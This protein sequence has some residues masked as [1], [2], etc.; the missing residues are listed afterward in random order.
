MELKPRNRRPH[1]LAACAAL[2][3]MVA[4]PAMAQTLT[5]TPI[6]WDV[7]GLDSND[8][9]VGPRDFPVGARICA[10]SGTSG[11]NVQAT[12]NWD[13]NLDRY[14]GNA[15]INLRTGTPTNSPFQIDL[16]TLASGGCV[17]AYFEVRVNPSFA[18]FGQARRYNVFAELL[19]AGPT[20]NART[21][22]PREIYVERLV[23]QNRNSITDV[24]FRVAT[25]SLPAVNSTPPLA[26]IGTSVSAGASMNL[27]IGQTYDIQVIG[28]TATQGYEQFAAFISFDR[29]IFRIVEVRTSY[30][31][32][33]SPD[34]TS[35]VDNVADKL[36]ADACRWQADPGS[37]AIRSC[38]STGKAG[39]NFSTIYRVQIIGGGGSSNTLN[40]LVYDYSGSSYHYNADNQ[41]GGRGYNII[42]PAASTISKGF[43]PNTIPP[44]GVSVLSIT[45][46][47]PNAGAISGY[48]FD[49]TLPTNVV[50][51]PGGVATFSGCGASPTTSPVVAGGGT[52]I[53]GR[54]ITVGANSTCVVSVPVT[55]AIVSV[56]PNHYQNTILAGG[57]RID[58]VST[59]T[60]SNT[61][62]LIVDTSAVTV[63]TGCTPGSPLVSWTFDNGGTIT[64]PLPAT[65]TGTASAI[66]GAS[67][68]GNIGMEVAL[69]GSEWRGRHVSELTTLDTSRQE[70]LQ[71]SMD[72]SGL[73][74]VTLQTAIFVTSNGPRSAAIF[75]STLANPG[76]LDAGTQF[77]SD[78]VL[79]RNA[80]NNL[81]A[82]V[83]S[84]INLTGTTHFRIYFFSSLNDQGSHGI[85]MRDITFS[86]CRPPSITKAFN[87]LTVAVNQV[88]EL[89]FN[90]TNPNA[91]NALTGLTVTDTL[92]TGMQVAPT[93]PA[94]VVSNTC[95]GTLNPLAGATSISLTGGTLPT[96]G[97][98]FTVRVTT[99]SVGVRTNVSDPVSTTQSGENATANGTA[100]AT[101][102]TVASP[103]VDKLFAT[104]P[105][106]TSAS[107]G[108]TRLTLRITNP[109]PNA[110]LAAVAVQDPFPAGMVVAT[111]PNVVATGCGSPSI[112]DLTNNTVTAGDNGIRVTGATLAAGG[113][114]T[115]EVNVSAANAG[116]YVN[117]TGAVTHT[118]NG[119]TF[120]TD[121]ATA[122]L[123]VE[124]PSPS[125]RLSKEVAQ[126]NATG[127]TGPWLPYL[128][129]AAATEIY[130]R[131]TIE[132]TGDV[133]LT[134]LSLVDAQIV[135]EEA[136][137]LP[138]TLPV[139]DI[140]DNDH[141]FECIVGRNRPITGVQ[142]LFAAF[143][144]LT[145]TATASGVFNG[146]TFQS[147]DTA[148]Y[149]IYGLNVVKTPSPL[150]YSAAGQVI[151][152]SFTVT[153]TGS[154]VLSG[155]GIPSR[156][157]INDP[158]TT[159]ETC[160]AI[161]TIGNT[162]NFF[163]PN[164]VL[165]C[166]ATYTIT[167][168]DITAGSVSN[169]AFVEFQEFGRNSNTA[170][171]YY[172]P[173]AN[174]PYLL[175]N[176]TI[177]SNP[178]PGGTATYTIVVTNAGQVATTGAI[179]IRDL[180]PAQTR[181]VT[182]NGAT[183]TNWTCGST[184]IPGS[185]DQDQVDCAYAPTINAGAQSTPL[186]IQVN[187]SLTAENLTN[188]ARA[189]GGGDLTCPAPPA[190]AE[191]HCS[192][193]VVAST[194]PVTL[195]DVSSRVE[196]GQLVVRFGT[197]SEAGTLGFRV[198]TSNRADASRNQRTALSAGIARAQRSTF[199]PQRYELRGAYTG[200]SQIWIE[201]ITIKGRSIVYGPYPVGVTTGQPTFT[202]EADWAAVRS[203]QASFQTAM[204]RNLVANRG[205][206]GIEVEIPVDSDGWVVITHDD[207][208][209]AGI[210]WSGVTANSIQLFD[211]D[212]LKPL[213]YEG[214]SSFGPGSRLSFLGIAIEDDLYTRTRVYRLRIAAGGAL[215][216]GTRDG[217]ADTL[218]AFTAARDVYRYEPDAYYDFAS[219]TGDPWFAFD[220][221]RISQPVAAT[222]RTFSLPHRAADSSAERLS[223]DLYGGL[224]F[225]ESPDHSVRI[226]LN[227]TVVAS[228]QF[229]GISRQRIVAD[230]P[231]GVLLTGE[232]TLSVELVGDTGV[233]A[234]IVLVDGFSVEYARNLVAVDNRV[235]FSVAYGAPV[236]P[237][238]GD[239]VF[240]S[241]FEDAP[242]TA[243]CSAAQIGCQAWRVTGLTTPDVVVVRQGADGQVQTFHGVEITP[244]GQTWS[245]RFASLASAN[246][247]YWVLPKSGSVSTSI[248][249]AA[250]VADPLAGGPADYLVIAHP[251][252]VSG[253]APLVAARQAEGFNVRVVDVESLYDWYTGGRF[254]AEAV[255]VA[256]ADAYARL[257]T[258]YVL[259][260][261]GDTYDYFNA[262]G[263]NSVSFIP[264]HY[265]PTDDLVMFAPVDGEHADVNNDGT[266]DVAI[267]R[268]PVRTAAELSAVVTKTLAYA[269]A[270]P[271]GKLLRLADR[272][273]N[274][275]DF[276]M[277]T[278]PVPSALP[279]WST[280]TISLQDYPADNG[281]VAQARAALQ[282]AIN[283]G[284]S[285]FTY[286]GHS[287]PGS[288]TREGLVTSQLVY[289]GLFSNAS[290]P[291]VAWQLGC[292]GAYFVDPY[293]NTIA[294]G[295]ML[296]PNGGGAAALIGASALTEVGNDV[297]WMNALTPHL[298]SERIGDAVMNAQRSM[299]SLGRGARDIAI[300]G[301][302]L[303]DPALRIRQ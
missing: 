105:I 154:A 166:S 191:A 60:G 217:R 84:G 215:V 251:S 155:F 80:T 82:N 3:G 281:G 276:R 206:S 74:Q 297:T 30:S 131:F 263:S 254:G 265:R 160:V 34:A 54:N 209:A 47:N 93:P 86:A 111:T 238:F 146:N 87:P 286:F 97:C 25:G 122:T 8:P 79:T 165:T 71:F 29:T 139:A 294:H 14:T 170:T 269:Q 42:D 277:L 296:Q 152:Y 91:S 63:G 186:S 300:G 262:E 92:P 199:K 183:G 283:D 174:V 189:S 24:R 185:P 257:G 228:R 221:V 175:V 85:D 6:T 184:V 158:L 275:A 129:V 172:L 256:I 274:G 235:S 196:N 285:L 299:H 10:P 250:P 268:L 7:V 20:V 279:G 231:S 90:V 96:A 69:T 272:D 164:E 291:T 177:S 4:A 219:P 298:R 103:L 247:R 284:Q 39:G 110:S 123:V 246:D 52:Q 225:P 203:E 23:S 44:N 197:A 180:L 192:G 126:G 245:L 61:A 278:Q 37:P 118:I 31:A 150:T 289:E 292:W 40:S 145:N 16:G 157:N 35:R 109:N 295:L 230:I 190:V 11:R 249:P 229:D 98:S 120:G 264:T 202:V 70:Y 211:G 240:A 72:T 75:T 259:L 244:S 106:L 162:N 142:P 41:T 270:T 114:C 200:Q 260:V 167:G 255:S 212:G 267:G 303:G 117:T 77:G 22:Q 194:V 5:I 243:A 57:F 143:P 258:R 222:T 64:A 15:H 2:L 135:G 204:R 159:N 224:D 55:S 178:T 210:D 113:V 102:T 151:S 99:T 273:D 67:G 89:T 207:L 1:W 128:A 153:N 53:N 293:Y 48:E 59:G 173:N 125:I 301:T 201:E 136:C 112:L 261:G 132:N 50:V 216:M 161:N 104:S 149:Q 271:A 252:F 108:V 68:A 147:Q 226:K 144:G 116:S 208:L 205:S 171:V 21:P 193:T 73:T 107:G 45:I 38:L 287:A 236:G 179:S 130:Y 188:T 214:R 27:A 46:S 302:L 134:N 195:S 138:A 81:T 13:D 290:S 213:R 56:A 19:D 121:T 280:T 66:A 163:D 288:W 233:Y 101:L 266:M 36:Y 26:V 133:P 248:A 58:G 137:V 169:T 181:L 9:L 241:S 237:S 62:Q 83:T 282:A 218:P 168:A 176:K 227:G 187:L 49:D 220:V 33:S 28:S 94:T 124:N 18:A 95:G 242:A 198:L 253:L 17:D 32:V 232:N 234:D 12:F 65:G 78:V 156:P 182:P 88:S 148:Q 141:I 223:V 100:T 140:N 43:T 119:G 51:A 127:P 115:V 239:G 76:P